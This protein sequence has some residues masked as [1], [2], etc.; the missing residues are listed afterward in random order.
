MSD[1]KVSEAEIE[2]HIAKAIADVIGHGMREKCEGF[3]RAILEAVAPMLAKVE[4][5]EGFRPIET[6]PEE[7]VVVV[8]WVDEDGCTRYEFDW[9]ED[10]VWLDHSNRYDE[11]VACAPRDVHCTGPSENAPYTHWLELPVLSAA[12]S[13]EEGKS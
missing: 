2:D 4:V 7:T 6:A 12:P 8:A 10:G 9:L 3:A 13:P 11:Y 1:S 5:P